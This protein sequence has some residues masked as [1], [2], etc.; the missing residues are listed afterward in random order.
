MACTVLRSA[1]GNDPASAPLFC[2]GALA[3]RRVRF[4]GLACAGLTEWLAWLSGEKYTHSRVPYKIS[5]SPLR[6]TFCTQ[7]RLPP[8]KALETKQEI[9]GQLFICLVLSGGTLLRLH[10]SS[11]PLPV[12]RLSQLSVPASIDAH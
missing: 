7:T 8:T 2:G 10:H 12:L 9:T 1:H 11:P 3:L 5:S 4:A 6:E